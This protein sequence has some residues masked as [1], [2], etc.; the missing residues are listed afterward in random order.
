MKYLIAIL[1]TIFL[2]QPLMLGAEEFKPADIDSD[3]H[4]DFKDLAL[5]A[6]NWGR[7]SPELTRS[8]ING[9]GI[10]DVKDLSILAKEWKTGS[11]DVLEGDSQPNKAI[12]NQ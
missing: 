9:D 10:V 4:I 2:F 8:D 12:L 7:T 6:R 3:N 5:I 11:L 1:T